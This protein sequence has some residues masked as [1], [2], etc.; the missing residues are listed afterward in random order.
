MPEAAYSHGDLELFGDL[1]RAASAA[2]LV[3]CL[4]GAGA[5]KMGS[6]LA[7]GVRLDR[8][9]LDWDFAVRVS[10]W[11]EFH[12]LLRHLVA[13]EGGFERA[14]EPHRFRH[15]SGGTLDVAPYGELEDPPG[16]IQWEDGTR[17]ATAG[18]GVLD[19][20]H[21]SH[22]LENQRVRVA[23]L[24]ALLGLK[25]LAYCDRRAQTP[26][27][28]QDA[29]GLLLDAET[30]MDDDRVALDA[31]HRLGTGD[32]GY[33]EVGAYLIGR[34]VGRIYE[35]GVR[36]E[37]VGLL[38]EIVSPEVR[39]VSDVQR[40]KRGT[41]HSRVLIAARFEAFRLGVEDR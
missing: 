25:F 36:A 20:H 29:F 33:G 10:S 19:Q 1:E 27:D 39:L 7:W 14:A 31:I 17:M 2:G 32:V 13:P 38:A 5:I 24:P 18:L 40:S 37:I 35:D 4:I 12:E 28:V 30:F 15:R 6:D 3:V 21:E 11:G 22:L 23:S 8:R 9:T 26:R 34:D 16:T 41:T